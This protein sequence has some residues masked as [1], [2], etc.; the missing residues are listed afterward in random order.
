[1]QVIEQT[2]TR[3][4]RVITWMRLARVYTLVDRETVNLLRRFD[5]SVAQFDV[6]AQVGAGEGRTQQELADALLVTKGNITQLLDRLE[7][8]GLIE[9]RVEAGRRGKQ[10]FL[11]EA[12]WALNREAIPAQEALIATLVGRLPVKDQDELNQILR[13]F[14][15]LL[16]TASDEEHTS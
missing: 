5:L 9:R 12:G 13:R 3:D 7:T 16:A 6:I 4:S 8:R 11:A 2:G 1:M 14:Q 15:H 10:I